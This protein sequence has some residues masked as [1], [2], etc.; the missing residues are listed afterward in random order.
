MG[1]PNH[2]K[3]FDLCKYDANFYAADLEWALTG[4]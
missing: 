1:R 4:P 2:P 3:L